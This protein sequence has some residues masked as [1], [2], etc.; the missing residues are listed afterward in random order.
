M[1]S[2]FSF[3]GLL[4]QTTIKQVILSKYVNKHMYYSTTFPINERLERQFGNLGIGIAV[5]PCI[6]GYQLEIIN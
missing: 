2:Q 6:S 5:F 1:V 3:P 4:T